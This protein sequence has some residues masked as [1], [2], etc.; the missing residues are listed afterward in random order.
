M[1]IYIIIIHVSGSIFHQVDI[2]FLCLH[3]ITNNS[4]GLGLYRVN[5][6]AISRIIIF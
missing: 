2:A 3:V 1:K 4:V 5:F 6:T